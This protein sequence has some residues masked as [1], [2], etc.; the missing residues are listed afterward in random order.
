MEKLTTE[1]RR[2]LNA[3]HD[4]LDGTDWDYVPARYAIGGTVTKA[5]R[6]TIKRLRLA[7][8]MDYARGGM[9][10]EG[11]VIGGTFYGITTAG[12]T[13]LSEGSTL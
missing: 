13:A 3:F 2:M 12:R 11:R 1:D 5:D 6:A 10:D 7:G 9:D 8:L 4:A